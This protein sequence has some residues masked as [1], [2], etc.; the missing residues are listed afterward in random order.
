M[1][2]KFNLFEFSTMSSHAVNFVKIVFLHA[3]YNTFLSFDFWGKIRNKL[4]LGT[5]YEMKLDLDL[6]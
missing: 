1:N 4:I 6:I 3:K 2:F 5:F